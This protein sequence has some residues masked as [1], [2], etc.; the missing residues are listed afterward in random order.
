M[1]RLTFADVKVT[2][3]K[4]E[5]SAMSLVPLRQNRQKILP[6]KGGK[7]SLNIL[8]VFQKI[9]RENFATVQLFSPPTFQ[10]LQWM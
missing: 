7:I 6:M 3:R 2:V 5:F 10:G 1:L 4:F 9:H 8:M